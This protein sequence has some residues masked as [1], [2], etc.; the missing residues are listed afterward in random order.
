MEAAALVVAA[1][2]AGTKYV[3]WT[4]ADAAKVNLLVQQRETGT[5]A[6]GKPFNARDEVVYVGENADGLTNAM[7]GTFVGYRT[8]VKKA[9][10]GLL[11]RKLKAVVD[12]GDGAFPCCDGDSDSEDDE[13][14]D[15]G[16]VDLSDLRL[17]YCLT[18]HKA[19]GSGYERVCVLCLRMKGMLHLNCDRRWLYTAVSRAKDSLVVLCTPDAAALAAREAGPLG[20]SVLDFRG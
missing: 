2:G 3:A 10:N 14:D 6:V 11:V 4:N 12:W 19:Q 9:K 15:A 13:T 8:S 16:T 20:R 1:E 5:P 18:V 7:C 17:A